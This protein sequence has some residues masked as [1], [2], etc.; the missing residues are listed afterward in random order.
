MGGAITAEAAA[1]LAADAA[2]TAYAMV[3]AATAAAETATVRARLTAEAAAATA[4][5]AAADTA[6][7]AAAIA[8][9][10][11]IAASAAAAKTAVRAGNT[12][13]EAVSVA[14]AAAAVQIE[15]DGDPLSPPPGDGSDFP[16]RKEWTPELAEPLMWQFQSVFGPLEAVVNLADIAEQK[17]RRDIAIPIGPA[18]KAEQLL[19]AVSPRPHESFAAAQGYALLAIAEELA[20]LN[21]QLAT[22]GHFECETDAVVARP[23]AP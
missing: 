20:W 12:A 16:T 2:A 7:E 9:A 13:A 1:E 23:T 19:A 10:M 6:A 17:L 8:E 3:T 5:R 15:L 11:V 18:A 22:R 21:A 14:L 4:A